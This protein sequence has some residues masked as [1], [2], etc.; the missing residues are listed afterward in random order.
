MPKF[1]AINYL[2]YYFNVITNHLNAMNSMNTH[3]VIT[4]LTYNSTHTILYSYNFV[5]NNIVYSNKP[6]FH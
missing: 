4:M 5:I 1:I 3:I 2:N 6:L